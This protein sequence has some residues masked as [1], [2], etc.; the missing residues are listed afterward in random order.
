MFGDVNPGGRLPVTFPA[1]ENQV[2]MTQENWPGINGYSMYTERLLIG[3]RWYNA[4]KAAPAYAFGHGL[5]YTT[6]KYSDL[7]VTGRTVTCKIA[8]VG[9]VFGSEV[10]QLYLGFPTS[11]GEPP[12]QLKG[13]SKLH[14]AAGETAT[15]TF[16]LDDRSFSIWDVNSHAWTVVKGQFSVFVGASSADIRLTGTISS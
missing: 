10:P 8:N 4:H 13:F 5:S 11:A 2:N 6:F 12:M 15:A 9:G 1:A 3:Y 16:T 14:L 7:T